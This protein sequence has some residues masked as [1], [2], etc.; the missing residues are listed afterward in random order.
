[1]G[2]VTLHQP[3]FKL[4]DLHMNP[5]PTLKI[6]KSTFYED[7]N[8]AGPLQESARVSRKLPANSQSGVCES[9][10]VN[11]IPQIWKRGFRSR[12]TPISPHPRKGASSKKTHFC[13][14]Q[15]RQKWGFF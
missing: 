7:G 8:H 10:G 1:M 14:E 4:P 12:K 5:T 15:H 2:N 3:C 6:A 13:T 11:K 9:V